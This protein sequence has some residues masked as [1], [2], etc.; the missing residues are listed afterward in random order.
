MADKCEIK[1]CYDDSPCLK[2][3]AL[4]KNCRHWKGASAKEQESALPEEGNSYL[5][6]W[7]ANSMGRNDIAI[8]AERSSPFLIG[9]VGASNAGKTTF[10]GLLYLLMHNGKAIPGWSFAGS[11]STLGW[12]YIAQYLRYESGKRPQMPP[13]T[14]SYAG[15]EVGM[16]HLA[17]K[18][19]DRF[20]DILFTD[21]PGEWFSAWATD[22]ND[23]NAGNA[24]WIHEHADGFML[25]L[26]CEAL[27]GSEFGLH[28]AEALRLIGRLSNELGNR[29]VAVL[30]AKADLKENIKAPIRLAI[31][32][33]LK[34]AFQLFK[35]FNISI[36]NKADAN[37]VNYHASILEA[38]A[39]L[40][41]E[42]RHI[43]M[44]ISLP[45]LEDYNND[46]FL[47]YRGGNHE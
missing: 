17:L 37:G 2:G 14:R 4:K 15:R 34:N 6:S 41:A 13:H 18:S 12:E 42:A 22:A 31:E 3:E 29:P 25:F 16:L 10:L 32:R 40:L 27:S 20:R 8:I 47:A 39:W 43:K 24:P 46:P 21:V 38:V 9:G 44:E 33:Q 30:W 19:I 23:V 7:T 26:D 36:E 28:R 5:P 45:V 1:D 35:E 11:Y